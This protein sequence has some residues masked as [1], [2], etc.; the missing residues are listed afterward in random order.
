[1][2]LISIET[3]L[4]ICLEKGEFELGITEGVFWKQNGNA[5]KI[6]TV[7]GEEGKEYYDTISLRDESL[8]A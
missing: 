7:G 1:M 6:M 4:D 5:I 3:L 2:N 8:T